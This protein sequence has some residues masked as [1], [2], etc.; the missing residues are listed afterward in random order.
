MIKKII[1]YHV[2]GV[3]VKVTVES[4]HVT[5]VD[6]VHRLIEQAKRD[7]GISCE[8]IDMEQRKCS[9]QVFFVAPDCK[10]HGR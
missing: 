2:D 4:H 5:A 1:S 9:C 8:V 3:E 10:K 7:S 6:A